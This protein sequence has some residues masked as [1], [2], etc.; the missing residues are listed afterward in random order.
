MN[1]VPRILDHPCLIPVE[2]YTSRAYL[3][4]ESAKLWP[5]VWQIACREEEIPK[6]GDYADLHDV[7]DEFDHRGA[8]RGRQ[9]P[10][11]LQRLPAP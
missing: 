9:D 5:K 3:Q 4:A 11:V 7:L 8:F 10:G 1:D 2:A 6:V